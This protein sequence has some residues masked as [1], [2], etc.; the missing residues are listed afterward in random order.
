MGALSRGYVWIR[1]V[2]KD[3]CCRAENNEEVCEEE[4]NPYT[5]WLGRGFVRSRVAL[6]PRSA[7]NHPLSFRLSFSCG[8]FIL[9]CGCLYYCGSSMWMDDWRGLRRRRVDSGWVGDCRL[10]T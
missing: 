7:E 9:G 8:V 5:M 4:D 1:P 6:L 2:G 3:R 10:F